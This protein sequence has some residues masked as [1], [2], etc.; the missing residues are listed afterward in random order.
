MK[1]WKRVLFACAAAGV[2]AV[3]AFAQTTGTIEGTV[4]DENAMALPG[5]TVEA[6]SPNLQGTKVAVTDTEGQFRLVLLPPG[7]YALKFALTG[8]AA[9]EQSGVVVNLGRIVTLAV[10][11]QSAFKEEVV[12][13]GAAP[14]IDV[15]STEV[16]A[17][18]T[19]DFFLNLPTARNYASVALIAPG[20]NTDDAGTTVYG[21]SGAENAYYIDGVNTTGI[22]LA[23]QGKQLN[24]EF[25]QEVQV[26]TGGYQAEFGRSTG[27]MIN[28]IT[29]SGGNEFHGDVFA[30]YDSADLQSS[31]DET[32]L[33]IARG[34]R[35]FV[36]EDYTRQDF[37]LDLGGFIVKDKL[38]FF[39]AY[40][41]VQN[42]ED[43]QITND[44]TAFG[45]PAQDTIYT[46]KL[47]RDLWSG[48]LTW[49]IGQNHSL[50]ASAFG[51]PTTTE[52][53]LN[54]YG[55]SGPES[56]FMGT[57]DEGGT[58]YTGKY[59]G[60]LGQNFVASAQYAWHE[61]LY[62]PSASPGFNQIWVQDRTRTVS[63][64]IFPVSGGF[65]FAQVQEFGRETM[66][67]DLAYF[68]NDFLGDHEF[69]IGAEYEQIDVMSNQYNTGGQRIRIRCKSGT[70][71]RD[72]D[73]ELIG[74]APGGTYYQ[75]E[76]YVF[77]EPPGG[78]NDPNM[79]DYVAPFPVTS[80]AKNWAYFL[81]DTWRISS[82]FTLNLGVRLDQQE[83]YD[84][85]GAVAGE[86]KDSYAPR[87]GF[88]WD[89]S[90]DGRT[91]LYGSWGYFY[92][93]VPMDIVIRSFGG[94]IS[95]LNY[96]LTP[97]GSNVNCD[98]AGQAGYFA[99]RRVGHSS[100]PVDPD[101]KGQYIEDVVVGFDYELAKDFAVGA[102]Y[103]W[104]DLA[105]VIE[106]SLDGTGGYFIG[107]PGR[108]VLSTM[109]D[110][111]YTYSYP[112]PPAERTF[113]GVELTARKRFSNNWQMVAS[114]LW[115]EMKGNYD[116]TFQASTGQL[117]PNLNSAFDYAEFTLRNNGKLSNDRTHQFKV[118]GSYTFDFGLNLGVSAYFA[119][120]RPVTAY[121]YDV[122]YRNYEY[123][124]SERGAYGR[125][126]DEYEMDLHLG[127]PI[128]LG[129]IE[130][131]VLV[132]VFNLLDVQGET[133]RDMRFNLDQT[134][135]VIDY[136]TG[137]FRELLPGGT[138]CASLGLESCNDNF[139]TSND[140]QDP[141]SIR[142]GLRL[143]F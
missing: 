48:K 96:N 64:G 41:Q 49:R 123:Y 76:F 137:E 128:K 59:E 10:T 80:N 131:N 125:I 16:G 85:S 56:T 130:L 67:G 50:I 63:G 98:L 135:D 65:G 129:G 24:F 139:N 62:D 57:L 120:G 29:K 119:S 20:T 12:V 108:G 45:G 58:D 61:E 78:V 36:V 22:E 109:L 52:G 91:K 44:Y 39:A 141:R 118:D 74:C 6:M 90:G 34:T 4:V 114:Y 51:D 7:T 124:L 115:S 2:L 73:G 38:W 126:D 79:A 14:T 5:V 75:H 99:C 30:Y 33:E 11:M 86:I 101:L 77:P 72:L 25:I 103:I 26:K 31:F 8:F 116:G 40:D 19:S 27:G 111:S 102:K 138:T 55:L 143:T 83:F 17:N 95:I 110:E 81:Q 82:N 97:D 92:E 46:Q 112:A 140:F 84:S 121:G 134:I 88:I 122:N 21:S 15:K 93:T 23:Q 54:A 42:D 68:L 142:L 43:R 69:K 70:Q 53:P 94:E 107:N 113:T 3:G 60:V 37:G 117:D 1:V 66:K 87:I 35:T 47:K 136:D 104:R 127:Y 89:P 100:T 106:D 71:L 132:D 28:V 18:V 32:N 9:T 133:D 105:M 13:S